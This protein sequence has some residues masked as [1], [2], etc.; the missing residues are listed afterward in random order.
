MK[1]ENKYP[2]KSKIDLL[3]KGKLLYFTRECI[4]N[5]AQAKEKDTEVLPFK[6]WAEG[7]IEK[8]S[9]KL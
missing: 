4:E 8:A 6:L 9:K 1:K 2:G 5:H 7:L 3:K